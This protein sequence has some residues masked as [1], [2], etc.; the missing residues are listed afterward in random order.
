MP[1][2]P[3]QIVLNTDNFII[4]HD[5]QGGGEYKDFYAENDAEFVEHKHKIFTQLSTI[6][7]AQLENDF[8]EISFAKLVLKQSG[9]A[10]SHRPTKAI[11]RNDIAPVIG[12]GDLGELFVELQPS[13]IEKVSE[14][15]AQAEETTRS[16]TRNDGKVVFNPSKIR[17]ELGAIADIRPYDS[18]EKRRFSTREGMSWIA[19]PRTAGAY[20]VE[21]FEAPPPRHEWDALSTE[22]HRL[23]SSFIS[24]L[25]A[26]QPGITVSRLSDGRDVSVLFG[27]KI[28]DSDNAASI[29]LNFSQSSATR[30]DEKPPAS[31]NEERHERLLSFL[32]SHPLVKKIVLPPIISQSQKNTFQAVGEPVE[33]PERS[34]ESTYPI[35][36]VI[37]GGVSDHLDGW[38]QDEW[39]LLSEEDKDQAHG[40]FIAGLAIASGSLN[41][42]D[43]FREMDGCSVIDLDLLPIESAFPHYYP[44]PLQFFE[45]L[46]NAIQDLKARTG[47]RVFNFSLNLDEH[48]SADSYSAA[49]RILDRIATDN[50][51]LFVISAGNTHPND[52]R[53]EWPE[54]PSEAMSILASARNDIIRRPAESS[55][56]LCISALNPPMGDKVVP[57][58]F[59]N[60][61]CRGPGLRIGLKPDLA[62]VGGAGSKY[63]D[64]GHGLYS[65]DPT[66]NLIDG[67]GTSFAAPHVA[68]T[69]ACLDQAI[70][71]D[72]SRETLMALAVHHASLP[73]ELARKQFKS[74]AKHLVGFGIPGSSDEILEGSDHAITLVFANRILTGRKLCFDFTWPESLVRNGVCRG[75]AKLTLVSSPPFDYNYGSEFVRINIDGYLR[76]EQ[77]DGKF[78]G[79]LD[80]KYLPENT[81][82]HYEK[83][84]IEHAFKWSPVK[85]F[86]K[87]F[88]KGV[89]P[90][91]NWQL[92]VEYLARDGEALPDNGVP[93]T[94]LLT[95]SDPDAEESVFEDM[96][97]SLTAIGVETVDIKTAAR[98]V[99]RV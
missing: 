85:V 93:F 92:V 60:Y 36:G 95:I 30:R 2:S 58:A 49:A 80:P 89:G 61:S 46:E 40:T 50:D 6:R 18:S 77:R 22:K 28:D 63:A 42:P 4:A 54:D 51:V 31:H 84:Q 27:V 81:S 72:V 14:K 41:G 43:V 13:S 83:D 73:N 15:I 45:E 7:S 53:Q 17:S 19:D 90:S 39:G 59:S 26:F 87:S 99:P 5:R 71:G 67:C 74:I 34:S 23:F 91:A 56:N 47:V 68:K 11:F 76:Q 20:I 75:H 78:K 82:A 12:A 8:S 37:D 96:R 52:A 94:A 38:V 25:Q 33:L 62:H 64:H 29:Q 66:G 35:L 32:D 88:P 10:K 70:E 55:R 21:V 16:K 3:V 57:Y 65:I 79:R 24:G 1:N 98:V 9:I 44:K 97:Q 48:V 69:L 86:E